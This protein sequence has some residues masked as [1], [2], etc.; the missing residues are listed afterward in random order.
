LATILVLA[1]CSAC[2]ES[3]PASS[4]CRNL[5][6]KESGLSRAEYLPCAGEMMSALDDVA[7][8]SKIAFDGDPAARSKGQASLRRVK[9][10][11][12]AAGGRNLLE[13][14]R[15]SRLTDLNLDISN[16]VTHYDA[17]YMVRVLE[18]PHQ[19]A[20]KTREAAHD[21]LRGGMQSYSEARSAYRRLR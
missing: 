7:A 12:G 21:E 17:F 3:V 2:A 11:M 9:A 19:F 16:A 15:D 20:A 5:V 18:E 10:L 1:L 6:Y 8:Q 4:A 14:W 13:R